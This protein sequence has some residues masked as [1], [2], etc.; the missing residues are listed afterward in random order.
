M[1]LA[2]RYY[3]VISFNYSTM[4]RTYMYIGLSNLEKTATRIK[5]YIAFEWKLVR[6]NWCAGSHLYQLVAQLL[7]QVSVTNL[8]TKERS[9]SNYRR[10]CHRNQAFIRWMFNLAREL[11][12]VNQS[13]RNSHCDF[14]SEIR[15]I[16]GRLIN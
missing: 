4:S 3:S 8:R 11:L 6:C 9:V 15:V 5:T 12:K 7:K 10:T 16:E 14:Q 1:P 13:T 2:H